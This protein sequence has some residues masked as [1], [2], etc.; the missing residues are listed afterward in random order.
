MIDP[1]VKT[2]ATTSDARSLDS[3]NGL[4]KLVNGICDKLY[5]HNPIYLKYT[6]I[7]KLP[8]FVRVQQLHSSD[9]AVEVIAE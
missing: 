5:K 8:D 1:L 4:I 7:S 2:I 6:N 9:A 3:K